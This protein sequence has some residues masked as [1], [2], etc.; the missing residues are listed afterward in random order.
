MSEEDKIHIPPQFLPPV[1]PDQGQPTEPVTAAFDAPTA[2]FEP[3]AAPAP[4]ADPSAAP[5]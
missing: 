2:A 3:V 4:A 1:G 5:T